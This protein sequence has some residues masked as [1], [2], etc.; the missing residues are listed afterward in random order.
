MHLYLY[1]CKSTSGHRH[2]HVCTLLFNVY[3]DLKVLSITLLNGI[4]LLMRHQLKVRG[5]S[6]SSEP[7]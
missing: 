2:A 4:Q 3:L 6:G 1:G 5:M 7:S